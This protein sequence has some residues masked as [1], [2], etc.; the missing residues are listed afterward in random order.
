M[1]GNSLLTREQ[2]VTLDMFLLIPTEFTL[3]VDDDDIL[4]TPEADCSGNLL[5]KE[6]GVATDFS[7]PLFG[8]FGCNLGLIIDSMGTSRPLTWFVKTKV[9]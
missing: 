8:S 1:C 3:G 4:A 7:S 9:T 5:C 2:S 6:K